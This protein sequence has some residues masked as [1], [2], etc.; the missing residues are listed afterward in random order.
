MIPRNLAITIVILLASFMFLITAKNSNE[1]AG[2]FT[3]GGSYA[4]M[5]IAMLTLSL[6]FLQRFSEFIYYAF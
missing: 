4:A 5:I 3:P 1:R 6:V 2:A